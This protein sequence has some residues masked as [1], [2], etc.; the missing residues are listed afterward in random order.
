MK[1]LPPVPCAETVEAYLIDAVRHQRDFHYRTSMS[2]IKREVVT[3]YQASMVL[4]L[5][6]NVSAD[7]KKRLLD[8]APDVGKIVLI[9][10][11]AINRSD[12]MKARMH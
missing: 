2:S 1:K 9:A 11:S 7:R 8:F 6:E 12:T 3:L 4:H 5:L 10:L